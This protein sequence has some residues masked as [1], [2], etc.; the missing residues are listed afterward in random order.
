VSRRFFRHGE[1][2]LVLLA[3]VF[4][5]PRHGYEI[6]AELT[7][8]FGP[9]Y[10]PSPGSVYPAI[11]A[12]EAEGLIEGQTHGGKTTYSPTTAGREALEARRD[13]LAA[14]E[15]RT[16]ARLDGADSIEPLLA[17]F[18]AR[19]APLSGR[20]DPAAVTAVLE[21]A[22]ADIEGLDGIPPTKEAG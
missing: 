16:G 7:R 19:I 4:E 21:R 18:K 10:R 5:S 11:E 8:L 2:P 15:L 12:L 22:A 1:L 17:R 6:M 20:V 9:R 14:L 3:L 13:G